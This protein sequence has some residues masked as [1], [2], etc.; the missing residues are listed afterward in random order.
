[1]LDHTHIVSTPP[2]SHLPYETLE[3]SFLMLIHAPRSNVISPSTG[4]QPQHPSNY[5]RALANQV[6]NKRTFRFRIFWR[7]SSLNP[8]TC[9][10]V[11]WDYRKFT[12]NEQMLDQ[13]KIRTNKNDLLGPQKLQ[14]PQ[15]PGHI[16][17]IDTGSDPVKATQLG[18]P[19]K[20]VVIA[21]DYPVCV[22]RVGAAGN[23][24]RFMEGSIKFWIKFASYSW[25]LDFRLFALPSTAST[26]FALWFPRNVDDDN[27][28]FLQ[29][30]VPLRPATVS[31]FLHDKFRRNETLEPRPETSWYIAG[32]TLFTYHNLVQINRK[33]L[34]TSRVF[35]ATW[36]TR[37]TFSSVFC[38][39]LC[40]LVASSLPPAR[41]ALYK[42]SATSEQRL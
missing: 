32:T 17:S 31:I 14:N 36:N 37:D 21:S 3:E 9:N 29:E 28:I 35:F 22:F 39:G 27:V 13:N 6:T 11:R 15:V 19:W 26:R 5:C 10:E 42:A 30:E 2:E 4:H 38:I 25:P 34:S 41:K 33:Q 8:M 7:M 12:S 40:S 24:A 18:T 23:I 1:M 20:Q 16:E